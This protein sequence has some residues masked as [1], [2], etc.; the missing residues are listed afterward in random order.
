MT[1]MRLVAFF[2]AIALGLYTAFY[3]VVS[4]GFCSGLK[5]FP[6]TFAWIL[7]LPIMLL[8][9]WSFRATAIA[10]VILLALHVSIDVH[11]YG[12]SVNTL[13]GS[14]KG[15]DIVL[16][17]TVILLVATVSARK[18]AALLWP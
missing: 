11:F 3:G 5:C 8:G 13:W 17:L 15:L 7:I 18:R 12:F 9:I 4:V 2:I 6:H 14:D 10:A 1:G 16:W